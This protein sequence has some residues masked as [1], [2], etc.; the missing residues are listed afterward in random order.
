GPMIAPPVAVRSNQ[1]MGWSNWGWQYAP[2]KGSLDDVE[3]WNIARTADQIHADMTSA[4]S[5]GES[6]LIASY[7]F[8]E[9]VGITAH[10]ASAH[11]FDAAL[12]TVGYALPVWIVDKG[13]AIDLGGDGV[14]TIAASSVHGPNHL[15][16]YPII[17]DTG[18]GWINGWLNSAPNA[19]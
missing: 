3:I 13:Q 10:D 8:D 5:G 17:I 12:T 4:P 15:Q 18:G 11:H 7:R 1:Y 2:F 16:N 19:T 9:G 6:G 14:T